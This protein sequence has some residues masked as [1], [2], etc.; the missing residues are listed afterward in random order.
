MWCT[1]MTD[2][3]NVD[4]QQMTVKEDLFKVMYWLESLTIF[5]PD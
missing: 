1:F 3:K 2:Q 4:H 5:L